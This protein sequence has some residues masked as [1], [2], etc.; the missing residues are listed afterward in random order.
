MLCCRVRH[1]RVTEQHHK[2]TTSCWTHPLNCPTDNSKSM[3]SN[4]PTSLSSFHILHLVTNTIMLKS[5]QFLL[6]HI[7][8][9]IKFCQLTS[10]I[11][12]N[13][14]PSSI[15]QHC[16]NLEQSDFLLDY[17]N[18]FLLFLHVVMS[19]S[20]LSF[21]SSKYQKMIPGSLKTRLH[22]TCKIRRWEASRQKKEY[23]QKAGLGE[24][25]MKTAR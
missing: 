15:I 17:S 21:R 8:S 14:V 16:D 23:S 3:S 2:N 22:L 4:Q 9:I 19:P 12:L 1:D 7:K 5:P 6:S 11:F 25:K 10:I 24:W 20:H 18:R 13:F